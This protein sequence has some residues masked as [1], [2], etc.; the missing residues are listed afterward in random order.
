MADI[1]GQR[2][3]AFGDA[4]AADHAVILF[5]GPNGWAEAGILTTQMML[6]YSQ[7]VMR[8]FDFGAVALGIPASQYFIIGH[9]TGNGNFGQIMGPRPVNYCFYMAFGNACGVRNNNFMVACG[10]G[11]NGSADN[12]AFWVC[13]CLLTSFGFSVGAQDMLFSA[14]LP[15]MF[16]S[17]E[18]SDEDAFVCGVLSD[19]N[20]NVSSLSTLGRSTNSNQQAA[21]TTGTTRTSENKFSTI[22][23]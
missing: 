17:L 13:N 14:N 7:P 3:M 11:C 2:P 23:A 19:L 22:T 6:N 20:S 10:A 5:A 1:F 8:I 18:I 9:P 12:F 4:M 21:I 16:I 15:F